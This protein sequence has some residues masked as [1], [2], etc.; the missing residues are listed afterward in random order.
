M[1]SALSV[2]DKYD[3]A[4]RRFVGA[5]FRYTRSSYNGDNVNH[6]ARAAGRIMP[7]ARNA[8]DSANYDRAPGCEG[9]CLCHNFGS[10]HEGLCHFVFLD[11]HVQSL[12]V[13]INNL[14]LDALAT[15]SGG[16]A[17]SEY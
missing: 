12:D 9:P 10:W 1:N 3:A 6:F 2:I 11:V 14:V 4:E 7:L 16:E 13:S 5:L 15:R 17:I 8:T